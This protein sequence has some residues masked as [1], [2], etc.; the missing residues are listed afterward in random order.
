[1]GKKKKRPRLKTRVATR[2]Q[3]EKALDRIKAMQSKQNELMMHSANVIKQLQTA[4]QRNELLLSHAPD[5][6]DMDGDSD[7][8]ALPKGQFFVKK[9]TC[10]WLFKDG[11][12]VSAFRLTNEDMVE[13][14][15]ITDVPFN[16]ELLQEI[17]KGH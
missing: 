12:V 1:L 17:M 6:Y 7:N 5:L 9:G 10:G 2:I 14:M 16:T 11:E 3:L 8:G 13:Q 4:R 15:S